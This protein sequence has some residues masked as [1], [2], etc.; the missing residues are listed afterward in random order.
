[1]VDTSIL[2]G[3]Y[4]HAH[5]PIWYL[6]LFF[7][8]LLHQACFVPSRRVLLLGH[9]LG[10]LLLAK[11]GRGIEGLP[12]RRNLLLQVIDLRGEPSAVRGELLD[13]RG[14]I[15]EVLLSIGD[16][17]RLL[18]VTGLTPAD[19]RCPT[20]MGAFCV[21]KGYSILVCLNIERSQIHEA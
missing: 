7:N 5:D 17:L 20:C 4:I 8:H 19:L 15:S 2:S 10:E 14:Q 3:G 16:R 6:L 21:L 18:L 12:V 13:G 9:K 1:M 11:G